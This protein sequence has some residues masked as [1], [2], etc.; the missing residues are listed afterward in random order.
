MVM[1]S[2]SCAGLEYWPDAVA[3]T[4]A[5]AIQA[6]KAVNIVTATCFHKAC[7]L[8]IDL[9]SLFSLQEAERVKDED[10]CSHVHSALSP[11]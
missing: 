6:P 5:M 2:C 8:R 10:V 1:Q 4:M 3:M 7:A 11:P 9:N